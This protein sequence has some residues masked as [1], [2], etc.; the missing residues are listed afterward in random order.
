MS[1]SPRKLG[2]V[3]KADL[4]DP[5]PQH[6]QTLNGASLFVKSQALV[7]GWGVSAPVTSTLSYG[8]LSLTAIVLSTDF[9]DPLSSALRLLLRVLPASVN[10]VGG[11][12]GALVP[13]LLN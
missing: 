10:S 5:T 3:T 6:F 9:A 4:G 1:L 2:A 7:W 12:K 8:S 13:S 11:L